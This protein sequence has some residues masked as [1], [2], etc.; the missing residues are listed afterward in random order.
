MG[1]SYWFILIG[2]RDSSIG[3]IGVWIDRC[4]WENFG[5]VLKWNFVL[6]VSLDYLGGCDLLGDVERV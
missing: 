4:I 2:C 5:I 6:D 1:V 3:L